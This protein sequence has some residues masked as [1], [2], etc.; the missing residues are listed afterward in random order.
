MSEPTYVVGI[1]LGTTNS[2]VAYTEAGADA[3]DNSRIRIFKIPQIVGPGTMGDREILPSFLFVPGPHDIPEGGLSLPWNSDPRL[4]VGEFARD[5]GSEIIHRVISSSKSW[6]CHT[7]VD[8]KKAILP[9]EGPEDVPK[10][11]PV[12]ASAAILEHIKNAWN[13]R[14]AQDNPDLRLEHQEIYLTVPASFDAV[15]R[16]LTVEAS[17]AAGLPNVILIE[18]PQ[19]AFYAWIDAC[20][21]N[22]RRLVKVG[23]LILVVDI[24]GGTSDFSLI[25]VSEIEGELTLERIAVGEHL[26]VGGDNMDLTLAYRIAG[27][28][29]SEGRKISSHQIRALTHACRTAKENLFENPDLDA[30][31]VTLLGR[32][33]GL[34][35]GTVKT[36]VSRADVDQALLD[37]FFPGCQ[38]SARPKEAIRAGMREIGLSYASDPAVTHHLAKFLSQ[39]ERIQD[40][41]DSG[42][43]R[44]TIV[45]FNG[46]VMK[47][48]PLRLRLLDVL[49]SWFHEDSRLSIPELEGADFDR[50]V[51]RG[52]AYYGLARRGRGVR[53]R[54]GLSRTYYIGVEA[55]LPAVPGVPTPVKALCVAPFGMEEGSDAEIPEKEFGLVVGEPVKFDFLGS[56]TRQHDGIGNVVE[57][58]E[59]DIEEITTLETRLE[60]EAGTVIPVT[61]QVK[62]TEV[63]TLEIWCASQED[64]SKFKL[65]FN[66]RESET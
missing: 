37:G 22:W 35:A 62:V 32:G 14:L 43:Y 33:S 55:A 24:G 3:R 17:Q 30:Y 56:R 54:G 45:L 11:S 38:S 64:N 50:A 63:G 59:G 61:L 5:R 58:W 7:G 65:E 18:E 16:N 28:M 46:G 57:D 4:A 1:D 15:A 6:L 19:A 29:A 2:V 25:E 10:L 42:L 41:E 48:A 8:R 21:E 36:E 52:A 9:W 47:A 51:A 13:Y 26:L 31:P 60:G 23:E 53:I 44:P 12:E 39:R 20:G 40:T 34:I 27:R 66:V 49:S